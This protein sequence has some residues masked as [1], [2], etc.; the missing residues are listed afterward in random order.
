MTDQD[1]TT[2][3]LEDMNSKFDA[4]LEMVSPLVVLPTKID[5]MQEDIAELKSDMKV[6]KAAIETA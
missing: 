5:A 3:I 4:V 2:L 1:Y 6:V